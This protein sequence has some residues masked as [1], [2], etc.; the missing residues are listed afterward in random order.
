MKM[1][2]PGANPWPSK[3]AKVETGMRLL[4][5]AL[6]ASQVSVTVAPCCSS[7]APFSGLDWEGKSVS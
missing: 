1:D 4:V 6:D 3:D 7:M 2:D 5:A